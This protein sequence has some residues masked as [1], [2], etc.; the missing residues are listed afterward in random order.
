M[1]RM[2]TACTLVLAAAVAAH[3]GLGSLSH[4]GTYVG[5]DVNGYPVWDEGLTEIA[6]Y[7]AASYRLFITN[8]NDNRVDVLSLADPTAPSLVDS[9][10]LAPYGDAPTS[11]A[12]SGGL[13]AVSVEAPV[14]TDPGLVAFFNTSDLSLNTTVTVGALPDMVAFTPSGATLLV[15]N[16]GE[17]AE[18]N[19]PTLNPAGSI[20]LID[21]TTFAVQTADFTA[22]DATL[23]PGADPSTSVRIHPNVTTPSRDI[24]PEYITVSPDGTTAF[25]ACQ[26]NNALAVVD[27][28]TATVTDLLPLG[29]K[30]HSLPGNGLDGYKKD[31]A[32]VIQPEHLFGMY[33]PDGIAAY[34][35]GGQVY[36]IM[37][38]EGDSRDDDF[39][40]FTTPG[41]LADE[42]ELDKTIKNSDL[43]PGFPNPTLCDDLDGLKVSQNDGKD[44]S[45]KYEKLFAF[46]A[47]SFSIFDATGTLVYD[48]GDDFEQTV[49]AMFPDNFNCSDDDLGIDDRSDD[50]GP[51]PEGVALGTLAGR[52]FAFI[53]LEKIGGVMVYD[54]TDPVAPLFIEYMN[55]RL[56]D[57]DLLDTFEDYASADPADQAAL[58]A[59]L[60]AGRFDIA[61][62]GLLFIPAVDSPSGQDLLVVANEV[63]G[64]TSVYRV[65]PEPATLTLVALGGLALLRKRR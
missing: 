63:S 10:S 38:N 61:P 22:F 13:I 33:M 54:V 18:G 60:Q 50:S 57:Q 21:T 41:N 27:I 28:A 45:G 51:E 42:G 8:G 46:G 6:A 2:L 11:V 40:D 17:A 16:E 65:V 20:S 58:M 23:V 36:I 30:D 37:A 34:E 12:V 3:A 31:D 32:A 56:F 5:T 14:G 47:R 29:A 1:L 52:T 64:T 43:A 7:D 44:G 48:S 55:N 62:E 49:A 15:A 53:G 26:E 24:E 39:G 19:P 35:V 9:I 4:L 25:V 59:A